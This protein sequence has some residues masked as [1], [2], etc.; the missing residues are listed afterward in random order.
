MIMVTAGDGGASLTARK[1]AR[2]SRS[3]ARG[4][5][6]RIVVYS[7]LLEKYSF[8]FLGFLVKAKSTDS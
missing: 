8:V 5:V 6:A 7:S 4:E 3:G 1:R 2:C